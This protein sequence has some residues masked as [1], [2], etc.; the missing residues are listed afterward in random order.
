MLPAPSPEALYS[1]MMS[2]W[3]H[4]EALVRDGRD[5]SLVSNGSPHA[6]LNGRAEHIMMLL[7]GSTYLPGD[8]LVKVDRAAM[9]VSL[10]T[11]I[12]LLDHRLIEFAW[13]LPLEYKFRDGA[14]KWLLRQVLYRYVPRSLVDRPKTGF[15][16]PI[17]N[18]LRGPLRDWAEALLDERRLRREGMLDSALV[19]RVWTE[20]LAG[21][22]RDYQLWSVLMFQSWNETASQVEPAVAVA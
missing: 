9:G 5:P 2:H 17:A 15:H 22:R 8:I 11:R 20:H 7:D 4:P 3:K 16:L 6:Q 10:E 21:S 13:R 12:P 1:Y 18:W 19:R 14:S